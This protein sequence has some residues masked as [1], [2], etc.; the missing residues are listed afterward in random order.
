MEKG[1]FRILI[2]YSLW[3]TKKS[4]N[5]FGENFNISENHIISVKVVS[6]SVF[7]R[8]H[9]AKLPL[10]EVADCGYHVKIL[11]L[12]CPGSNQVAKNIKGF[13]K[14]FSYL[15]YS[16]IWLKFFA[17]DCQL[18]YITSFE[19]KTLVQYRMVSI[20]LVLLI[21]MKEVHM[22]LVQLHMILVQLIS[23]VLLFL[24]GVK[25]RQMAICFYKLAKLECFF[26]FQVIKF[27]KKS[28]NCFGLDFYPKF[29]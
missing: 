13:F 9:I 19:T 10:V 21:T 14:K 8:L 22:I 6:V 17:D 11:T 12:I 20:N 3:I 16:R 26:S 5:F 25:F 15:V 18:R 23:R 28:S 24:G 27:R 2:K 7:F 29:W 1:Y 4:L